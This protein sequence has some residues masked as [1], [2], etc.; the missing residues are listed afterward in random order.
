[1]DSGVQRCRNRAVG[2]SVSVN[3][4]TRQSSEQ[5]R[6]AQAAF[7][8]FY[9]ACF[10]FMRPDTQITEAD[11]PYLIRRLRADGGRRGFERAAELCR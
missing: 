8:E 1:M 2:Y 6:L 4:P 7:Q 9:H 11:L 10:W 3:R 5:M